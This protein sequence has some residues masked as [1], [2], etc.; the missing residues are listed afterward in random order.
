MLRITNLLKK[1]TF[2]NNKDKLKTSFFFKTGF[3]YIKNNKEKA[4]IYTH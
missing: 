3:S 4:I 1:I 2:T